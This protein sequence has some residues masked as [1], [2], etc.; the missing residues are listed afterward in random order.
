MRKKGEGKLKVWSAVG[1]L[2]CGED[3][4]IKCGGAFTGQGLIPSDWASEM[5]SWRQEYSE[6]FVRIAS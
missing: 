6:L 3:P 5:M 2:E 4:L 1:A